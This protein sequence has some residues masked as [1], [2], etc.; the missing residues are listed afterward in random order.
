MTQAD[1]E[2]ARLTA[3][4]NG[5]VAISVHGVAKCYQIYDKPQDRLKQSLVPRLQR[6]VGSS[7]RQYF[8]EFWALRGVGFDVPKG[9]T[10][11][12]IGR[13]GSGKSTLLQIVCGT[14]APTAG[15]VRVHGRVAALL[16][17]GSG[18]N[19]DFTGRENVF[20]NAM[21]L[22]LTHEQIEERFASIA[23][24]ADI[25]DFI[26]QPIK[27]YSSGMAV[28]LAFA[29]I[30][31]VDADVLIIDEALAVGDAV[32]T[33]KCMRYLRRFRETGTILFV[34]HDVGSIVALCS[35][36]VW[37]DQGEMRMSG[38]AKEVAESY[39]QYC[40]Q[41]AA[42]EAQAFSA[43]KGTHSE[44]DATTYLQGGETEIDFFDNVIHSDGWTTGMA[45]ISGV[46]IARGDGRSD[47]AFE[48]GEPVVLTVDALA[49][50][51]IERPIIGFLV[52]D[53]LGQALFGHNTFQEHQPAKPLRAG[54]TARAEFAFRLP[55]L[56]NGEYSITVA[57]ADGDLIDHVQHHWIHDAV[58]LAVRSTRNRYGL[59]GI[60]FESITLDVL[61]RA[62]DAATSS[63]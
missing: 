52:K 45:R 20:L 15:E 31:H 37:L 5:E 53:R 39:T 7:G 47:S 63:N 50:G 23:A 16:E 14:L 48:G 38:P 33:Q 58:V 35:R 26:E 61:P 32:F 13:N 27:T 11:G 57:F 34:S 6:L 43:L 1:S 18:F 46:S 36:A 56:P 55:L 24:F 30:A 3:P 29:V 41:Q 42:G 59:V 8:R 2:A 49:H 62:Q 22:G 10:V 54:D 21:V 28:R 25:G 40:A 51:D 60:P 44:P 9:E 19:P 12:I 4:A 17:L